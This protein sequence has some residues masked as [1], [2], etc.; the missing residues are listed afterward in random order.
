MAG[1]EGVW[2]L[3]MF[4]TLQLATLPTLLGQY[5]AHFDHFDYIAWRCESKIIGMV[6]LWAMLIQDNLDLRNMPD[7]HV[8]V[9]YLGVT[10]DTT[11]ITWVSFHGFTH[12][13]F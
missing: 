8:S 13:C 4:A 2:C 9:F 5:L 10:L 12:I 1:N 7:K 11:K 6:V 3:E